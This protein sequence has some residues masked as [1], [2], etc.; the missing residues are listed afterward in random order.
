[1]SDDMRKNFE[2]AWLLW[3]T[4][5]KDRQE[6]GER[7]IFDAG[8]LAG[9]A[10]KAGWQMVPVEPTDAMEAA[11]DD[12]HHRAYFKKEAYHAMIAAAPDQEGK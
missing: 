10:S 1:M 5:V 11:F 12:A 3:N 9:R 6:I 2:A 8:Y 4:E 7:E